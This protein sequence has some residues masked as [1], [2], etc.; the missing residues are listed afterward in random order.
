MLEAFEKNLRTVWR[1]C[2]INL[3]LKHAGQ[4][5]TAAGIIA[6]LA[7][8]IERLLALSVINLRTVLSFWAV[9]IVLILLFWLLKRPR[10]MQVSLLLDERLRLHER[11]STTLA[12]AD[13]EDPFADAARREARDTARRVNVEGH[14][15]IL[16]AKCWIY[17]VSTWLI[18]GALVLY[19]PQKDL[20]GFFRKDRQQQE[21]T[22]QLQQAKVD[23]QQATDSVKLA[24]KELDEPE[25]A[26]ALSK[27][28]QTPKDARPQD[29]KR[30]AI[31]KLG[32]LSDKIRKMQSSTQ[33]ESVNLMQKMLKQLRGSPGVF[34]QELRLALA[35]GNF[36][37]ASNLM[38]QIQKR[39]EAGSL[40]P[41]QKKALS[42]QLQALAKQL[43][44]LARK[45]EE[46]EKELEKL[47]LDKG[48]AK[49]SQ[50]QL[51]QSLQKQGL[52]AE[53]I[54][55]LLRKAAA[56]RAASSQ[57]AGL[58]SAM[59]ACGV[60]AGGL[61]AD[62]LAGVMEQ[63][64]ELE[65]LKQDFMLTQATL[66]E[67]GRAIG[68][69]GEGMWLGLGGQGPFAEGL[70]EK[71]GAGT[72]GPGMGYGPRSTDLDGETSTKRTRV[73]T[74]PGQGPVIASWYFQE[75]QIKGEAKR[76]F[77]E[78]VQAARDGAAEAISENQ[79]PRKYEDAIKKYFGQL[80]ESGG[81]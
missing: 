18:A 60:G 3:L 40:S 41:E 24:V 52:D 68:C 66:D 38:N 6:V 81:Q 49:L 31:R 65:A 74:E 55:E 39:L 64:D 73:R 47:G 43:Q 48:L 28:E 14:F 80:E 32:D 42:Q 34:S 20:L 12:L 4:V 19:M 46:L 2:S 1:R 63:L 17:A 13:S 59:A 45:N 61:S 35:K 37:Q 29:V 16:P 78:V 57:C 56:S 23:V 33:L 75:S 70:S 67:I 79:I 69:L 26:D 5:L 72:G 27:L 9:A 44:E 54:E 76:D 58:G 15:P 11:F 77:S 8:L 71:F 30:Q 36:A 10:R 22:E 25:L 62:E 7:V 21:R 50:E 51:R 53:R